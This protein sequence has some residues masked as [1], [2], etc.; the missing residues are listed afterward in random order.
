MHATATASRSSA[1]PSPTAAPSRHPRLLHE[2]FAQAGIPA[3]GAGVRPCRPPWSGAPCSVPSASTTTA[4]GGDDVHRL[5][6]GRTH[7][8]RRRRPLR[9]PPGIGSRARPGITSGLATWADHLAVHAAHLEAQIAEF[10]ALG[11]DEVTERAPPAA[12]ATW[13]W[14]GPSP[15]FVAHLAERAGHPTRPTTWVAWHR[16]ADRFLR[17]YLGAWPPGRPTS[18]RPSSR[19]RTR[20]AGWAR[21]ITSIPSPTRPRSDEPSAP[22]ARRPGPA[23]RPLRARRPR[24]SRIDAVV[25]LDLDV[26]F[27]VGMSEGVFPARLGRRPAARREPGSRRWRCAAA[28]PTGRRPAART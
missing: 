28:G 24:V 2:A 17:D 23:D 14:P 12:S 15:D 9:P 21:S 22:E 16:W 6:V 10:A 18:S 27:V 5:G 19:C 11:G 25:G 20:S 26:V 13:S 3:N 1:W 8:P 7:P 4:G